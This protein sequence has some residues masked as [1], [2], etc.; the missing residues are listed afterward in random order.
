MY[1]ISHFLYHS[2]SCISSH[3]LHKRHLLHTHH[4]HTILH[5]KHPSLKTLQHIQYIDQYFLLN[6][7][8]KNNDTAGMNQ[9]KY[10]RMYLLH[11]Y[12]CRTYPTILKSNH[13]CMLNNLQMVKRNKKHRQDCKLYTFYQSLRNSHCCKYF[14]SF[15]LIILYQRL[16]KLDNQYSRD[17]NTYYNLY[18]NF[19][20]I[21]LSF[22]D[23][24]QLDKLHSKY[25]FLINNNQFNMLY[26]HYS[27]DQ[28]IFS[29]TNGIQCMYIKI[30][31]FKFHL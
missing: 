28:N 23:I 16:C 9:I 15:H 10:H 8:H 19:S 27:K 13:C 20:I 30:P 18:D 17:L 5:K 6:K 11:K 29:N 31:H 3:N 14:S 22:R 4:Q 24:T 25:Y 21:L 7:T 26:N 2:M 1:S 12:P